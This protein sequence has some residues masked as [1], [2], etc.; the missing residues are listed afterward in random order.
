MTQR[1]ATEHTISVILGSSEMAA[2]R[3]A[4]CPLLSPHVEQVE[5]ALC[6]FSVVWTGW[7]E[8]DGGD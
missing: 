4:S 5:G 3:S 7:E 8:T 6:I 2:V 1:A